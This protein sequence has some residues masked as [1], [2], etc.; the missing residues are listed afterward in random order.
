MIFCVDEVGVGL[1][2]IGQIKDEEEKKNKRRGGGGSSR[3]GG[4][5]KLIDR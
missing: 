3:R 2:N 5:G 1:K 4:C